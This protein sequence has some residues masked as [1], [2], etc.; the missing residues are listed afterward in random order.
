MRNSTTL[1]RPSVTCPVIVSSQGSPAAVTEVAQ[2]RLQ[3]SCGGVHALR[4]LPSLRRE[5]VFGDQPGL[6][7]RLELGQAVRQPGAGRVSGSSGGHAIPQV[8]SAH[9]PAAAAINSGV[10]LDRNSHVHGHLAAV[11]PLPVAASGEIADPHGL[12]TRG[13]V[14]RRVPRHDEEPA[15]GQ[16]A[17]IT[18]LLRCRIR[19]CNQVGVVT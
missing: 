1:K 8:P 14:R 4:R 11:S 18:H 9:R 2:V 19:F 17:A 15:T 7:G 5:P 12:E 16:V 13:L 3:P 10:V 6:V